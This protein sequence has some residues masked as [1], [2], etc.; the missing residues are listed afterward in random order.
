MIAFDTNALIRMLIED[1]EP[2]AT[3]VKEIIIQV[4]TRSEQILILSEVMIETVWVLDSVYRCTREEIA[5][6]LEMLLH[7]S[8][9]TVAE[10]AVIRSAIS[11]YKRGGDFADLIIV[12]QSKQLRA[13]TLIS[14]DK[15]LQ[16]KFPG[17]VVE[18]IE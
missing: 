15:K 4:E 7:T 18:T 14:F 6:F 1:D 5:G 11:Q 2:Q 9:F 16:N 8:T 13:K 10:P 12:N 17:Y 3:R